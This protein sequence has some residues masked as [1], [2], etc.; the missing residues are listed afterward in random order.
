MLE[1]VF[2]LLTSHLHRFFAEIFTIFGVG[3]PRVER[4][5]KY[6]I[7][8]EV[9]T[10]VG[11]CPRHSSGATRRKGRPR[12]VWIDTVVP[13]IERLF[14]LT[15]PQIHQ[16]AQNCHNWYDE[17]GCLCSVLGIV[18]KIEH[19]SSGIVLNSAMHF[20]K[21]PVQIDILNTT[22]DRNRE[23]TINLQICTEP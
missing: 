15:Q 3:L 12:M 5:T 7:R 8:E 20:L 1:F 13:T 22:E 21:P 18:L 14:N 23:S 10:C 6:T 2:F 16:L 4:I 17:T 19:W 11:N 9:K